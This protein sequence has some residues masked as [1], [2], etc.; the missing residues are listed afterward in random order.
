MKAE[1]RRHFG[2][3]LGRP[4]LWRVAHVVQADPLLAGQRQLV[5]DHVSERR[6]LLS[7]PEEAGVDL[8]G[9]HCGSSY[10]VADL[11]PELG[12]GAAVHFKHRCARADN[13]MI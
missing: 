5:L 12:G 8:F 10:L 2:L 4:R 7:C 1:R 9:G 11:E 3:V 13:R 6:A